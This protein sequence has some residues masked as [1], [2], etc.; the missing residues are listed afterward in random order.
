MIVPGKVRIGR[1]RKL[2]KEASKELRSN[3]FVASKHYCIWTSIK[4][5]GNLKKGGCHP[6]TSLNE[7][8]DE[9]ALRM[10]SAISQSPFTDCNLIKDHGGIMKGTKYV[11]K[12][13]NKKLSHN[14]LMLQYFLYDVLLANLPL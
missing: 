4:R 1:W 13:K 2:V 10:S 12:N 14:N 8:S 11:H 5:I 6:K 9:N 7:Y 3:F